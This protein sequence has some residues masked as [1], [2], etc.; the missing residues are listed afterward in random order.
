M[1]R[2]RFLNREACQTWY[3][4]YQAAHWF[5]LQTSDYGV[6]IDFVSIQRHWRRNSKS[7]TA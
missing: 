2:E 4:I 1:L 6:I 7:A 3:S 5:T